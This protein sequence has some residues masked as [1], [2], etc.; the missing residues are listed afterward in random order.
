MQEP[1][2]RI[3]DALQLMYDV[4]GEGWVKHILYGTSRIVQ[5]RGPN[6]HVAGIGRRFFLTT[7][8]F[9]ISR[10][11]IY[12]ED[13]FLAQENWRRLMNKMWSGDGAGDWHPKEA[14]YDL[15]ISCSA[16]SIRYVQKSKEYALP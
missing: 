5:Y 9:E 16:L 6:A 4:S 10:A 7:R 2:E 14:L 8:I 11:L 1:D 13:T 15:M 3:T 12:S